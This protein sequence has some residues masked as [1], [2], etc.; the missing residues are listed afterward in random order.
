MKGGTIF[1]GLS[2]GVIYRFLI[3]DGDPQRKDKDKDLELV[4]HKGGVH[5]L[6]Y[7]EETDSRPGL[8]VSGSADRS[9]IVWDPWSTDKLRVQTLVAHEGTVTALCSSKDSLVSGSTDG[10]VKVWRPQAQ[11]NLLLYPWFAVVQTISTF[12][13]WV[14]S[15][16]CREGE[17]VNVFVGDAKGYL[18]VYL[19]YNSPGGMSIS[20]SSSASSGVSSAVLSSAATPEPLTLIR[21]PQSIHGLGITQC[22]FLS[23]QNFVAT[24]SFDQTV[25]IH[26]GATD[27]GFLAMENPCR[28]RY[29]GV[30]WGAEHQEL[31]L[32]DEFGYLQIWNIYTEK[33]LKT[34]RLRKGIITGITLLDSSRLL[35][36]S[37]YSMK[38][39]SISREKK[40]KEFRGHQG[41]VVCLALIDDHALYSASLDNTIRHWD[42]YDMSCLSILKE[43]SSEITCMCHIPL[44]NML[45]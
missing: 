22:K 28:C 13:C 42:P 6:T 18:H 35:I 17:T 4:G 41:P 27:R 7:M 8:L 12:D 1:A 38:L 25:Q 11:R 36:S 34:V 29:T 32:I 33:C 21:P 19:L 44:S 40:F 15:I 26:D 5:A 16:T 37:T 45:L 14:T 10:S 39:W 30:D 2:D 9:L 23:M 24:L 3:N 43:K 31:F 20:Q